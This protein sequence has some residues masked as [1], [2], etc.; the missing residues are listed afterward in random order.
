M[1]TQNTSRP[2]NPTR[3]CA[4]SPLNWAGE[5]A[6][7]A[8]FLCTLAPGVEKST[9]LAGPLAQMAEQRICNP[10]V[11]GSTPAGTFGCT[12]AAWSRHAAI[13][14]LG[15]ISVR[16]VRFRRGCPVKSWSRSHDR[17]SVHI[18]GESVEPPPDVETLGK[19]GI[20]SPSAGSPHIL[21]PR[22]KGL[23]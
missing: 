9:G 19:N 20:G 15:P 6:V 21:T 4:G 17:P 5:G 16:A 3:P 13:R 2:C 14:G 11:A 8:A 12:D 1:L 18:Y 22:K 10:P 7:G 23:T